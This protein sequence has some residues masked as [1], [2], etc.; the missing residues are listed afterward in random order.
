MWFHKMSN[1]FYFIEI[2]KVNELML[3]K[4]KNKS[5]L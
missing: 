4:N 3:L 1:I 2:G 5:L